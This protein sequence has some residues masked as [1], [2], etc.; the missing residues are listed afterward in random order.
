MPPFVL[1]Q[2]CGMIYD[3]LANHQCIHRMAGTCQICDQYGDDLIWDSD[4]GQYA[5]V[6]NATCVL[7]LKEALTQLELRCLNT[8]EA[9]SKFMEGRRAAVEATREKSATKALKKS[10]RDRVNQ[11]S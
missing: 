10:N 1:C 11:T 7:K 8:S 9:L 5:H 2:D 3:V 4:S 6:N